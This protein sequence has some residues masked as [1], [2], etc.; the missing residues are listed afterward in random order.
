MSNTITTFNDN[1]KSPLS[2]ANIQ[3]EILKFM[4]KYEEESITEANNINAYAF[5]HAS[6]S[7]RENTDMIF[8]SEKLDKSDELVNAINN[9]TTSDVVYELNKSIA[10]DAQ[11]DIMSYTDTST[12][13]SNG[14]DTFTHTRNRIFDKT[15][16]SCGTIGKVSPSPPPQNRFYWR[17]RLW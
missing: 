10:S 12:H 1:T 9:L 3:E 11:G 2:N 13:T 14:P 5:S 8:T 16:L 6:S 15:L 17:H 7:Q 4:M